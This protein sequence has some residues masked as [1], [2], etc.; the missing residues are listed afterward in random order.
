[1]TELQSR[2]TTD[3]TLQSLLRNARDRSARGNATRR[4]WESVADIDHGVARREVREFLLRHANAVGSNA[5]PYARGT[6]IS[7][8]I[9]GFV[10]G[11]LLVAAIWLALPWIRDNY[12]SDPL[13]QHVI[14]SGQF[15]ATVLIPL[16]IYLGA[17]WSQKRAGHEPA[18]PSVVPEDA[19]LEELL[20]AFER[21]QHA[22]RARVY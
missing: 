19:T 3:A 6:G 11:V 15:I 10:V 7:G 21:T 2:P 5:N 14:T 13:W 20:D 4:D 18:A 17:K 22:G 16:G 1:M 8:A 12:I 9:V